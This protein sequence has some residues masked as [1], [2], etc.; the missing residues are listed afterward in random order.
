MIT[1]YD[2]DELPIPRKEIK[3][4]IAYEQRALDD[5]REEMEFLWKHKKCS[6]RLRLF[7]QARQRANTALENLKYYRSLND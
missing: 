6:N 5:A 7:R 2:Y 1:D 3:S 4:C